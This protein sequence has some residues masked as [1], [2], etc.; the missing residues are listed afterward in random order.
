MEFFCTVQKIS[1]FSIIVKIVIF[2]W[3]SRIRE[4]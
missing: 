2:K 4:L 1:G 3:G